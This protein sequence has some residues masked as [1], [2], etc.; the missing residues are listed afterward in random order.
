MSTSS[1][2]TPLFKKLGIRPGGTVG[3]VNEPDAFLEW[4]A[5]TLPA[6]VE[7][8]RE[9]ATVPLDVLLYFTSSRE[10]AE[11]RVPY[12]ARLLAPSGGLWVAYPKK[13][14]KV[15]TDL[16]FEVVQRIGLGAGL[17]DNKSCAI[18]D[19]WT[20]VRFVYRKVDRP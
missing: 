18:D 12:L 5:P 14:A 1:S 13:A 6:D 7:V 17:V 16:A 3:V 4:L 10:S 20:A 9:R 8:M 11:S 19:T 2:A 15:E